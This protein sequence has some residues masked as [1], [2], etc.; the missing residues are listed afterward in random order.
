MSHPAVEHAIEQL[1]NNKEVQDV[2]KANH[3]ENFTLYFCG[4]VFDYIMDVL[5][6]TDNNHPDVEWF[7]NLCGEAK[8]TYRGYNAISKKYDNYTYM[9][10]YKSHTVIHICETVYRKLH[11]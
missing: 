8:M 10:K 5:N 6:L 4:T 7:N 3:L 2:A 9:V 11:A 1:M